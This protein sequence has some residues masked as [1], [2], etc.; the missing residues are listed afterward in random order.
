[1]FDKIGLSFN[2]ARA[3]NDIIYATASGFEADGPYVNCPGQDLLVQAPSGLATITG[4][5][6]SAPRAADA[7]DHP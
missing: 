4:T 7:I 1:M 6:K 3:I 5:R 2:V